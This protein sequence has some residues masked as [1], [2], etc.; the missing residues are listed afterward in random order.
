MS[1]FIQAKEYDMNMHATIKF[2]EYAWMLINNSFK[3]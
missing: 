2:Y 1:Y 3:F